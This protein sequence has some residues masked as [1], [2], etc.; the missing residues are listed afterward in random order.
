MPHTVD[1][2]KLYLVLFCF[3]LSNKIN[4]IFFLTLLNE[5]IISR[6]VSNLGEIQCSLTSIQK[7]HARGSPVWFV[8]AG[9][10]STQTNV[11]AVIISQTF[12]LAVGMAIIINRE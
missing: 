9:A 7:T 2:R 8:C 1:I 10:G 11:L 12:R 5:E 6:E 3:V 4:D